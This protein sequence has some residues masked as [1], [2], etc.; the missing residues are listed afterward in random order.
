MFPIRD[1][2]PSHHFPFITVF[3]ITVNLVVFFYEISLGYAGELFVQS[4]ALIPQVFLG[5][6]SFTQAVPSKVTLVSS[7]FLHAGLGHVLGNMW[8]LWIFGD[9]LEDYL[10]KFCYMAFYFFTGIFA[11]L[12]HVYFNPDSSV[13]TVGASGAVSGVLGGYMILHPWIRI[14]TVFVLG[15][16]IQTASVP[17]I[18]FLGL[19]FVMQMLGGMAGG[20]NVAFGAHIGGFVAG[21]IFILLLSKKEQGV[22]ARYEPLRRRRY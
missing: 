9:N 14:R 2:N 16:L 1:E 10:G 5:D 15:F 4:F 12:V 3:L 11:G 20:S 13:P 18:F 8:F 19:W 7:M 17:A 21:C 6:T 22:H